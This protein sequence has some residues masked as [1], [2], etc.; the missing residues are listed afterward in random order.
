M[1]KP[2]LIF[3]FNRINDNTKES[4]KESYLW[5]SPAS[6]LN[7]PFDLQYRFSERLWQEILDK[8]VDDFEQGL[9][10]KLEEQD[11]SGAGATLGQLSRRKIESEK[12]REDTMKLIREQI[13]YS[14]CCF[15][16]QDDNILMWSH[17]AENHSGI[18]LMYDLS[19]TPELWP[20][21]NPVVYSDDYPICDSYDEVNKKGIFTK[22]KHWSYERE[23]RVLN[24]ATSGK[25]TIN[26]KS[27]KGIIFG[28][29]TRIDK[30]E[31][32]V[33]ICNDAGY[34]NLEYFKM[35]QNSE[36]YKL[37]KLTLSIRINK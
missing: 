15:T 12:F 26:K 18:C 37:D 25:M 2:K 30:A 6:N 7:D 10:K 33:K 3:K 36:E 24:F 13:Q 31:E 8:L 27:L 28:C 5:F 34:Q 14:V 20:V 32:I 17:Y 9:A 23:W 11:K 21:F 1:S 16:E 19:E 4:L 29:R 35:K 22:S